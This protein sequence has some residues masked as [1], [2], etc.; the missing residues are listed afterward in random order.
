MI[1]TGVFQ[2]KSTMYLISNGAESTDNLGQ[3]RL[4]PNRHG[5]GTT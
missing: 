1:N 3:D 2:F 4:R 5:T